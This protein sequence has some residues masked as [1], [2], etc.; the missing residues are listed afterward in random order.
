M[1]IEIVGLLRTRWLGEN[2]GSPLPQPILHFAQSGII[3]AVTPFGRIV[4]MVIEF[5]T[6]ITVADVA[7]AVVAYRNVSIFIDG[8]LLGICF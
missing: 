5:F 2:L 4:N 8:E 1:R 7:I 3:S 6:S